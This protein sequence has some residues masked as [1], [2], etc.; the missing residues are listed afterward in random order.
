[1]QSETLSGMPV[2]TLDINEMGQTKRRLPRLT[3]EEQ[4]ENTLLQGLYPGIRVARLN[5]P[6]GKLEDH[7]ENEVQKSMRCF[8]LDSVRFRLIGASASAKSGKFYAVDE[9][10]EAAIA[11]RFRNG[12]KLPSPISGFWF[13]R[14]SSESSCPTHG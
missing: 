4:L 5:V 14:A 7:Q 6:P 8:D 10:Y 11:E 2:I 12:R 1:M 3:R 9:R 13:R